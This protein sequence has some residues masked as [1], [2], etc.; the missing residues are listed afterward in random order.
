MK[1]LSSEVL[2]ALAAPE[3]PL[4]QLVLLEFASGDVAL[5]TSNW[6]LVF[7]STTYRGAYGL[8][9]ISPI[10]DAPGEVRGLQFELSGVAASAISLALDGSDE[11]QG[12]PVRIL[13]ALLDPTTYAIID[14][15][16]EWTGL[17]DTMAIQEDGE[18]CVVQATAESTAV[19]LLRGVPLTYTHADQQALYPGDRAFEYVNAQAGQPVVWPAKEWFRR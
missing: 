19:D 3:V 16:Q 14:V 2:A 5:N 18:T 17:G 13:T 10:E 8:G 6:D 1:T 15:G 12:T 7:E 4:V 11:W 9:T